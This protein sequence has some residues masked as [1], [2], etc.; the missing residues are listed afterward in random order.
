MPKDAKLNFSLEEYANRL[1]K[2]RAAMNERG[3]DCLIVVDPSNMAW[4]TGYDGW[5]FYTHQCVIVQHDHE[6]IWWGRGIDAPGAVRTTYLEADSILKYPDHFV[7]SDVCHP[8]DH[9]SDL[10]KELKLDNGSVGVEMENFYFSAAAFASL[11]THLPAA[12][13]VD[14]T[15]LVNWQRIIKSE[16]ELQYMRGAA[17]IVEGMH[18]RIYEMIEPGLAKNE[19][20]AEIF[21]SGIAGQGEFWG[22]YPAI[23]PLLP[24][25]MD[26]TAAHLTWD[27][28]KL[29]SG[30]ITFFEIAGCHKRY[31]CP[32]S[33][34]ISLG[35]PPQKYLDA[36]K[37]V[38]DAMH[39]GLENAKPGKL[40]EDVA[41]AF[42]DTLE[43]HGFKKD[44]RTGYSIGLSYPPDWGERTMSLRRGDKTELR[45]NMTFHFMPALWLDDGGLEITE[46]VVITESGY[47]SLANVEQRLLMK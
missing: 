3:I 23:M 26:A 1:S 41:I 39:A 9:L 2:T 42:F 15:A 35:P 6:P 36:E 12:R 13:L 14:A 17:R 25:G 29:K 38:L 7:Q 11:Q 10:L 5:S 16:Q 21:R 20:A 28:S 4:L 22:D 30:D 34:T 33:R 45:Q 19:L 43:K 27:D 32:L 31:H 46:S 37:A 18:A 40:C 44:S 47:E 24:T 8:M